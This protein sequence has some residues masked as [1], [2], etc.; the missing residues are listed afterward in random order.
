E[1]TGRE[2][3]LQ[4]RHLPEL[5]LQRGGD[6]RRH[7]VGTGTGIEGEDLDGRVVD[8]GQGGNGQL[9]VGDRPRQHDRRHEQRGGDRSEDEEPRRVHPPGFGVAPSRSAPRT[10]TGLPSRSLSAPSTTTTSPA[11]RPESITTSVRPVGPSVTG[12]ISTV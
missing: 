8:L 1:G 12:R 10:C 7:H 5:P 4:T 6:R 3:L 11:A 2:H 9:V